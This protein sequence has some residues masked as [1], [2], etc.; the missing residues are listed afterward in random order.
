LP[1]LEY[2]A[3]LCCRNV[4]IC[5]VCDCC[6]CLCLSVCVAVFSAALLIAFSARLTHR[7]LL[8]IVLVLPGAFIV[9]SSSFAGPPPANGN[10][11]LMTPYH[12]QTGT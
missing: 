4:V 2:G 3:P 8:L 1:P 10:V 12:V 11:Y 9:A 5:Y 6:V 7:L